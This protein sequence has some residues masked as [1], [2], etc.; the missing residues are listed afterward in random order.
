MTALSTLAKRA[1][2]GAAPALTLLA[3]SALA[4]SGHQAPVVHAHTGSPPLLA[5]LAL[6]ALGLGALLW[7]ARLLLRRRRVRLWH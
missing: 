1:A 7:L 6:S 2:G 3:G 4:H 5:G